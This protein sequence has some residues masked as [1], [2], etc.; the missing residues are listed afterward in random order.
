MK[1]N[2]P[3]I[4]A[5]KTN[6]GFTLLEVMVSLVI[7]AG[8]ASFAMQVF[9][10]GLD[11]SVMIE[12]MAYATILAESKMDEVLMAEDVSAVSGEGE[13]TDTGFRYQVISDIIPYEGDVPD[14]SLYHIKVIVA[15]DDEAF[16]QQVELTSLKL[17]K[18]EEEG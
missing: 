3:Q 11:R 1:T 7:L 16:Q 17:V 2:S 6:H 4:A 10:R 9:Y 15:W 14:Y 18:D 13:F 5:I 8:I 12:G